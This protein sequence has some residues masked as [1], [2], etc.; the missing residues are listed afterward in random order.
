M[1]AL[2]TFTNGPEE[3]TWDAWAKA[4]PRA[5]ADTRNGRHF[6]RDVLRCT[7][8]EGMASLETFFER[9]LEKQITIAIKDC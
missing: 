9:V 1:L 2:N 5:D 6:F 7:A 8:L 4:K 3:N